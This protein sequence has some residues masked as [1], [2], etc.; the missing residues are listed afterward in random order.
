MGRFINTDAFAS[1]YQGVIGSNMFAY[2]LN[3]PIN[4]SDS[5]GTMPYYDDPFTKVFEDFLQ[6]YEKAD[7]SAEDSDGNPTLNAKLKRTVRSFATS[8][9]FILGLGLGMYGGVSAY[10]AIDANAGIYGDLVRITYIDGRYDLCQYG[11][12]GMDLTIFFVNVLPASRTLYKPY[13]APPSQW[14]ELNEDEVYSLCG[15]SAYF[16]GG[17][18]VELSW[19]ILGLIEDLHN[20]WR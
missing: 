9:E 12:E 1:T 5:S 7:E 13:S 20:I 2:C 3:N 11:Y 6:W 18:T 4:L 10:D 15:V 19:D 16:F 17:G 14:V 8:I